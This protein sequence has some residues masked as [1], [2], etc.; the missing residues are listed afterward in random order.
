MEEEDDTNWLIP[1]HLDFKRL[2]TPGKGLTLGRLYELYGRIAEIKEVAGTILAL[3]SLVADT[4]YQWAR[5]REKPTRFVKEHE[6]DITNLKNLYIE[7]GL[8]AGPHHAE[9]LIREIENQARAQ[10]RDHELN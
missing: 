7:T 1:G 5:G 2:A 6:E 9:Q 3:E 8:A 10:A 4:T